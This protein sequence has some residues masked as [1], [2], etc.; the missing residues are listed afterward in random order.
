MDRKHSDLCFS[1][2]LSLCP[3][4]LEILLPFLDV[5]KRVYNIVSLVFIAKN[6]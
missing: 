6:S 2:L 4:Q 5:Y 3:Q 1:A